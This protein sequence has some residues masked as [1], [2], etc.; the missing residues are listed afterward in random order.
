MKKILTVLLACGL[1]LA[2]TLP[3]AAVDNEFGGY[4]RTRAYM[5][6]NFSGSDSAAQDYQ[7]VDQRTR[8]FYTAVFSEDFKF[9]NQF[10]FNTTWGDVNNGGGISTDGTNIFRIKNSYANFNLGPVNAL[11]GLQYRV[12]SRGF[13]FDDDFAGL[14]LTYKGNNFSIPL[15]SVSHSQYLALGERKK[16][17][18]LTPSGWYSLN[19]TMWP[20]SSSSTI[21]LSRFLSVVAKKLP[22]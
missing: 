3:A 2:L 9:V 5:Q 22:R 8:L 12:L 20:V 7:A 15:K 6:K 10:E 19:T 14:A 18:R 17:L 13:L 4:F 21:F 1:V 11:V 16:V